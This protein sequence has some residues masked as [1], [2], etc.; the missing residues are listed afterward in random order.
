LARLLFSRPPGLYAGCWRFLLLG[1]DTGP[2][3]VHQI[4]HTGSRSLPCWLDLFARPF[5]LKQAVTDGK[6]TGFTASGRGTL[7]L[8]T[9]DAASLAGK[10]VT[11]TAKTS[12]PGRFKV[13]LKA[14]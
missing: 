4:N 9:G 5:L 11:W 10:S 13:E 3:R 8:V 12:E 14:E 1:I 7:R 6:V 2:K